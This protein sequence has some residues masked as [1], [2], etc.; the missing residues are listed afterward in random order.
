MMGVGEGPGPFVLAIVGAGP[1]STYVLERLAATVANLEDH[2][3]EIHIFDKSGQFGAGQVHS[4]RQPVTSYLNRIVGQ[5][6]FAADESVEDAGTLLDPEQRPTLHEWC[7]RRYAQTGDATFNLAP[8]D[9]PKRYIHGLALME[10]FE[11]Y[12]ALLRAEPNITVTLHHS[13]VLDL[14]PCGERFEVVHTA[15]AGPV[16]AHHVLMVTGHSSNDPLQSPRLA[17]LA[18]FAADHPAC[19]IPSAYPLEDTLVPEAVGPGMVVGCAG[20]GLTAIDIVLHLTE[21]TGGVFEP[22]SGGRLRYIPS[23][24]EPNKIVPFSE[25]GLFTFARPFNAKEKD[26]ERLEHRGRFLT[27]TAIDLLRV[28]AGTPMD[29]GRL[30]TR[31]QLDF[32]RDL[33]P[34][35]LLEMAYVYYRTLLGHGFGDHLARRV[36]V[37]YQAFLAGTGDS[38]S[39]VEDAEALAAAVDDAVA[40]AEVLIDGLLT[41]RRSYDQFLAPVGPAWARRALQRYLDVVFGAGEE[42]TCRLAANEPVATILADHTL[43]WGHGVHLT[44]N[45]FSWRA[46][47][48][49]IVPQD[50]TSPERYRAALLAFM[51]RDHR[52]AQQGNVENPAKAA[53]DGVWRDLRPVL[54]YAVDFGGLTA[55]SHPVFLDTYMRHHNRLANGAALEVME[56]IRTLIEDG[57]VDVSIGPRPAIAL[58]GHAGRFRVRGSAT[59]AEVVLDTFVDARVHG[60]DPATDVMPVYPNLLRRGLVRKWSNPSATGADYEPGGLDL[61]PEF[62][63]IRSDGQVEQ[64]LTFLGPPSEGVMFFQLG[65]LRPNQNHHVMRD[66]LCWLREFWQSVEEEGAR[67]RVGTPS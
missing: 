62:H 8:E 49:P 37:A 1:S 11:R 51:D 52:W 64:R 65:A 66:V 63:P 14:E 23:G 34:I 30:G 57:F 25:A 33:L 45:R 3:L 61:T 13:E 7:Q 29:L 24:R 15:G 22:R 6:T 36:R 53:A 55:E 16:L 17:P 26:L 38:G 2:A 10:S 28:A 60:F 42:I 48:E 5:V 50:C 32:E 41:G 12:V 59:G 43:T 46:S 21:G 9:W 47:I 44:A 54:G 67:G 35:V 20:M 40:D 4:T 31:R 19:F 27:E 56:R 39:R 18:R 58:D